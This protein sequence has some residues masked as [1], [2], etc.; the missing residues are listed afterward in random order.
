[1]RSEETRRTGWK[2]AGTAA[3]DRGASDQLR[4]LVDNGEAYEALVEAIRGAR[5]S[6]FI[7]QLAFDADCRVFHDKR[8]GLPSDPTG[9]RLLD[10]ILAASERHGVRVRILLNSSILLNTKRSLAR[11][12]AERLPKSALVELRGISRFPQLLHAKMAIVDGSRAFLMGSPFVNGYWDSQ[13]HPVA[14]IR[15]PNRELGGRAIHDVSVEVRGSAARDLSANFE[16]LW[17]AAGDVASRVSRES[18]KPALRPASRFVDVVTTEPAG[19]S[20]ADS[21]GSTGTLDAL[22][23]GIRDARRLIYI[24]H[25]YLSS[26]PVV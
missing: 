15:R 7:S 1:M 20:S 6:I 16:H 4:W 22:L 11:A 14:D 23:S 18:I 17:T 13:S 3:N 5:E 8:P 26:R 10:I 9:E 24:E 12:I 19:F 2:R 25:Q 21:P